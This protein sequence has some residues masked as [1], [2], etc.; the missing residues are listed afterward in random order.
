MYESLG[1]KIWRVISPLL[2]HIV[3]YAIVL[4]AASLILESLG[5]NVFE[6]NTWMTE[7]AAILTSIAL[8]ITIPILYLYFKHDYA[9][10]S[11][12]I[13]KKPKWILIFAALAITCSHGLS[14]LL[15]LFLNTGLANGYDTVETAIYSSS[16]ILLIVRGVILAPVCEELLFRG[17]VFRRMKEYTSFWP[18]AIVSSLIFAVYHMNVIQ[19]IFAFVFGLVLCFVYHRFQNLIASMITHAVGNLLS[20]ILTLTAFQ[21]PSPVL[22][23]IIMAVFLLIAIYLVF[24]VVKK[25]D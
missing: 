13:F 14:L 6:T 25:R 21:Y 22:Y 19:G 8:V 16:I 3:I 1:R 4:L 9:I 24:F 7:H 18:A 11:D 15:S 23:Y 17:L 5:N 20:V 12:E 10:R 2:I